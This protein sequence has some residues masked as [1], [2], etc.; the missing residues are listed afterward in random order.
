MDVHGTPWTFHGTLW[1]SMDTPWHAMELHAGLLILCDV[2]ISHNWP[3]IATNR[4]IHEISQNLYKNAQFKKK[5]AKIPLNVK[6]S[7]N[8]NVISRHFFF[9]KASKSTGKRS[10]VEQ[11]NKQAFYASFY[12]LGTWCWFSKLNKWSLARNKQSFYVNTPIT[13]DVIWFLLT[14]VVSISME[15]AR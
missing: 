13:I 7:D 1:N 3:K 8:L 14:C 9:Q 12:M 6:F 5:R 10:F 2:A 4:I 15:T 11:T